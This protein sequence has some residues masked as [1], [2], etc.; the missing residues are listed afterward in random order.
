MNLFAAVR[1]F[2][3][4]KQHRGWWASFSVASDDSGFTVTEH[5]RRKQRI[6]QGAAWNDVY[7][8][9]FKDAGLGCDCF[10]I[11]ARNHQ[12]PIMVPVEAS[13]GLEFWGQLKERL[14][15]P[16]EISGQCVQSSKSGAEFWWPPEMSA[17]NSFKPT[18][19][20]G[21]A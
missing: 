17:N 12:E 19:L 11:F 16:Q 13:G 21:A 6:A 18:P 1:S 14:L 20:R 15:F 4:N 3:A 5:Q 8:V 2:I 9:C 7:G 10:F